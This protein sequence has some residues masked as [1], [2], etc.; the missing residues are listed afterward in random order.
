MKKHNCNR[1]I[2]SSSATVYG[3]PG[4]FTRSLNIVNLTPTPQFSFTCLIF[5]SK[6]LCPFPK[7]IPFASQI[8]MVELKWWMN[9]FGTS[10]W[11][12]EEEIRARD[13]QRKQETEKGIWKRHDWYLMGR[14]SAMWRRLSR[15]WRWLVCVISTQ[16]V[17]IPGPPSR[18][19]YLFSDHFSLFFHFSG[20]IGDDPKGPMLNVMPYITQV[21]SRFLCLFHST[22]L[23]CSLAVD[24]ISG[25]L[26]S[27]RMSQCLWKWL[28]DCWWHRR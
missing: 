9:R 19:S 6:R 5:F 15:S 3:S 2:F 13:N 27:P 14:S 23:P 28:A 17:R 4:S 1:I 8:L 20:V 12:E 18:Q 7:S 21:L 26:R 10:V 24:V 16:S 22:F 25:G 11:T